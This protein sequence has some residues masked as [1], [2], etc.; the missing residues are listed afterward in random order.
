MP[1]RDGPAL[2]VAALR[3]GS[4]EKAIRAAVDRLRM[5][6]AVAVPPAPLELLGSFRGVTRIEVATMASAGRL[7]PVPGGGY[8]VQ[9]NGTDSIGRQRF[10]AAHEICHTFFDEA[11]RAASE[12]EDRIT[13]A[14]DMERREEYL[15]DVGA[16]HLLLHPTWLRDLATREQPSL[17]R[18]FEIATICEASAEATARQL[19]ALGV[20]ACSFVFWEPGYRKGER[21]QLAHAPLPG[22]EALAP[23]PV[24]KLRATRVYAAEGSPFFPLRKSVAEGTS[25]AAA[26]RNEGLTHAIE[27]FDVGQKPLVVDCQSQYVGYVNGN[28]EPVPRVLTVMRWRTEG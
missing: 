4:A 10:S 5:E 3:G 18:L 23:L 16:A 14:F 13:G 19:A 26:L 20:W 8:V 24:P 2:L 21:L 9:V 6:T 25:I 7:V 22:L 28:G 12:H 17:E 27:R 11:R 1:Q 15:C